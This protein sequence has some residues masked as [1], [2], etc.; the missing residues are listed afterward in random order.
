MVLDYELGWDFECK[1]LKSYLDHHTLTMIKNEY[2]TR[3][4][5]QFLLKIHGSLVE[6]FASS[7]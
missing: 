2:L 1:H 4:A 5:T 7:H 6:I 3:V